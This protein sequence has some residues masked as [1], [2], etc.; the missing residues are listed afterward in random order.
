MH[1]FK[2]R[3]ALGIMTLLATLG[4]LP[5]R[6]VAQAGTG[7][8]QRLRDL[9]ITLPKVATNPA[10]HIVPYVQTGKLLFVSGVGP[11]ANAATGKV[12]KDVTVDEATQLARQTAIVILS[13]VRQ[14]AGSLDNVSRV[15]KVFGMVNSMPDFTDQPKVINGCSDLFIQVFGTE[16]GSHARSAVGMATMAFNVVVEIES[17]FELM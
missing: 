2:R 5:E 16:R 14:A 8:E 1:G 12:G 15:V 13:Q 7:A 4:E 11:G 3:S 6:A 10:V 9:G 17:I